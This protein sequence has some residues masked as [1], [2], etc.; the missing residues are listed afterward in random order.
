MNKEQIDK[1]IKLMSMKS[2]ISMA[3][4]LVDSSKEVGRDFVPVSV[5]EGVV[6]EL[7]AQVRALEVEL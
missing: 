3:K 2:G 7:E 1:A 6:E 4:S 5:I